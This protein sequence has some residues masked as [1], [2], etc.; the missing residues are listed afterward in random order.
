[1]KRLSKLYFRY[2]TMDS[3][4]TAQLLLNAHEYNSRGEFALLLKPTTD[5]RSGKGLIESRAGLSAPCLDIDSQFNIVNEVTGM[6][7]KP[8]VIMV[9]EAQFL[10]TAQV[11]Q[12]RI[13]ADNL[14]IPVMCYGLKTNF[15]GVA[16]DGARA[17]FEHANRFE[18]IKT[19]CRE[20]NCKRKAMYSVRFLNG[21]PIFDGESVKVGDTKVEE[22]EYYYIPKCSLHF[23]QDYS[24]YQQKREDE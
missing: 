22:G 2:G 15:L 18:E 9:D 14:G 19:M 12:L 5:T 1:M 4:K 20:P 6:K 16:F 13:I 21:D 11:V 3:A 23:F 10:T 7:D 17:L 24:K 8:T